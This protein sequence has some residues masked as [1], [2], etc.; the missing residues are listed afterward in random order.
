MYR[1]YK[2]VKPKI[3]WTD[4]RESFDFAYFVVGNGANNEARYLND[5]LR[6]KSE[7]A[8]RHK[9]RSHSYKVDEDMDNNESLSESLIS[10]KSDIQSIFNK[11]RDCTICLDPFHNDH[12]V[13]I[14]PHCEH[15]FHEKCFE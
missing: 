12:K 1:F 15:V 10:E 7:S 14:M 13:K 3:T 8:I 4:F 9:L 11:Y 2:Q 5:Y 6:K